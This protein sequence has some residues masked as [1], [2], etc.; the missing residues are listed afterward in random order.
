MA[1]H[2]RLGLCRHHERADV[3]SGA[4]AIDRDRARMANK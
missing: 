1:W 4:Q 3:V 2:V